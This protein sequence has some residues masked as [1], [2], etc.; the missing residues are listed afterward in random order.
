MIFGVGIVWVNWLAN[1]GLFSL[2][3]YV[4]NHNKDDWI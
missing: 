1:V 2:L 4:T 3:E